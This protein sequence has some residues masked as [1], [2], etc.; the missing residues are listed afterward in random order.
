MS[1][2][3]LSCAIW[4]Q[5]LTKHYPIRLGL[6]KKQVLR[7]LDLDLPPGSTLGLV[8][9][10]G[11]GKSTLLNLL[12]RFYDPVSGSVRWGYTDLRDVKRRALRRRIALVTQQTWLFDDTIENNIR[13]GSP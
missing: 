7:G 3:E 13:Y 8:G 11:S 2:Q 6:S 9:P 10:N 5:A 4:A 12:M 1:R